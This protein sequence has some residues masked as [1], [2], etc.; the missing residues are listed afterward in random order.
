MTAAERKAHLG[1]IERWAHYLMD[2]FGLHDWE[3][4]WDRAINRVGQCRTTRKE[5]GLSKPWAETNEFVVMDDILRHEIAHALVGWQEGHGR[6][7]QDMAVFL[8]ARPEAKLGVGDVIGSAVVRRP[9]AKWWGHC[10]EGCENFE[11]FAQARLDKYA[12]QC[13]ACGT[14]ITWADRDGN[15][16]LSPLE[17][18][19]RAVAETAKLR[20]LAAGAPWMLE[21]LPDA[22]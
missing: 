5:I 8:G 9:R 1:K 15:V 7:W 2:E 19:G 10:S 21:H 3:F 12:G 4:K 17:R 20:E 16:W 11:A 6:V 22:A 14:K 13:R 18:L